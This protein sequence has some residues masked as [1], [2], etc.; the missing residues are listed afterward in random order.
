MQIR[1]LLDLTGAAVAQAPYRVTGEPVQVHETHPQ[2][3]RLPVQLDRQPAAWLLPQLERDL[4][5]SR[6]NPGDGLVGASPPSL[7]LVTACETQHQHPFAGPR[8]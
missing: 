6:K 1:P 7:Q 5:I 8:T 3:V 2:L 4:L